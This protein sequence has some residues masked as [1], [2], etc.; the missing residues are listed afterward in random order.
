MNSKLEQDLLA[1]VCASIET[2]ELL[3]KAVYVLLARR[4]A[5]R[6][7]VHAG[8]PIGVDGGGALLH[9]VRDVLA[10]VLVDHLASDRGIF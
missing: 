10:H 1:V 4:P 7:G 5:G 9:L 2:A 6:L 3:V 8:L